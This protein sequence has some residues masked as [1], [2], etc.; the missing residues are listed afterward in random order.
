LK[1]KPSIVQPAR[2]GGKL[3]RRIGTFAMIARAKVILKLSIIVDAAGVLI[4]NKE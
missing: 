4:N 2:V 1:P 3:T